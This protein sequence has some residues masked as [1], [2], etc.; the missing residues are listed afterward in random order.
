MTQARIFLHLREDKFYVGLPCLFSLSLLLYLIKVTLAEG[1]RESARKSAT[2]AED[3]RE[4]TRKS[5][6]LVEEQR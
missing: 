3:L 2:L 1:S 4:S 6:A 5:A